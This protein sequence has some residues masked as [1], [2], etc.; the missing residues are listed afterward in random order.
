MGTLLTGL[1]LKEN[2]KEGTVMETPQIGLPLKENNEEIISLDA[3]GYPFKCMYRIMDNCIG[4]C[5]PWH[6]HPLLEISYVDE[7]IIEYSTANQNFTLTR[8]D[9]LF[10]NSDVLHFIHA[11]D[12]MTGCRLHA[13][14]FDMHFL[15]G[16]YNSIFEE[17]YLRPLV[18]CRDLEMFPIHP[19]SP[20]RLEMLRCLMKVTELDAAKSFGYEFAIRDELS[21]F[22]CM[23]LQETE[24]IRKEKPH[25]EKDTKRIK[26]MMKF[27]DEHFGEKIIVS[28]I[29]EAAGISERECRRAFQGCMELSPVEYLNKVRIRKAAGMLL[30]GDK[31]VLEIGLD[32]GFISVS[33]FGKAFRGE[34]GCTPKE[35]RKNKAA[36]PSYKREAGVHI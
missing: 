5:F 23:L 26:E 22:F 29:A 13:Y 32:C 24:E 14:L 27:I 35:Y 10:I 25:P 21:R 7:G 30:E 31:S 2:S 1:P 16:M 9:A 17:K 20:R 8:G 6:W 33:Y 28:D 36:D 34:M 3:A 11:K 4:R 18:A 12:Q 15:T 19:D